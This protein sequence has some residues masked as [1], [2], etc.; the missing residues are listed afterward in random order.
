MSKPAELDQRTAVAQLKRDVVRVSGSDALSYLQGQLSQDVTAIS[1]GESAFSLLLE[2]QGKVDA[3]LRITRTGDEE[4]LL[5]VDAGWAQAMVARL[6]RF[7]LRVN[8]SFEVLDD[9]LAV[10][11]E[12]SEASLVR[13]W[14]LSHGLW[15]VLAEISESNRIDFLGPRDLVLKAEPDLAERLGGDRFL[16]A[17]SS[18]EYEAIRIESLLPRMG[19]ELTTSTIPAEAGVIDRSVSFT[20]GCYTGQE[21]VARLDARGN[22]VPRNLRRVVISAEANDSL[23]PVGSQ[24]VVDG[25]EVGTLTSVAWSS[26][27][28]N[29]VAL[30]YLRRE[31]EVPSEAFVAIGDS[32]ETILTARVDR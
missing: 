29:V 27:L 16:K 28:N 24:V 26:N 14:A 20:K 15:P 32:G 7:K 13:E 21:L 10:A 30:A 22:K 5:D 3:Y 25:V 4:F 17:V 19:S 11:I 6:E 31:V 8:C 18:T 9:W 1:V 23:P 2:P 12:T